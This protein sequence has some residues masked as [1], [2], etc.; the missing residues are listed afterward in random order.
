MQQM[1][2]DQCEAHGLRLTEQRRAVTRALEESSD[3]PDIQTLH[4][5][6]TRYDRTISIATVYR[7]VKLLEETGILDRHDFGDGTARYEVADRHHHDH[8][9]DMT[10]GEVI[11]FFDEDIERLQKGI[12]AK[13]GYQLRGH[14]M[15]LYGTPL[16][17]KTKDE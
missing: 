8:L 15:E 1:I 10:T 11:E 14:R 12:A 3:H 2:I 16:S 5:R 13:L 7:T 9:I 6:A 17:G 4:K